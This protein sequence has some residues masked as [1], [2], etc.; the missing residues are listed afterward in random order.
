MRDYLLSYNNVG[1]ITE[2]SQDIVTE[3]TKNAVFDHLTLIL[4]IL[5]QETSGISA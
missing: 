4:D 1:L 2:G 5:L 3:S